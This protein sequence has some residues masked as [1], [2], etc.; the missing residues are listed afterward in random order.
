ML[1]ARVLQIFKISISAEDSIFRF[2]FILVRGENNSV[3]EAKSLLFTVFIGWQLM[4]ILAFLCISAYGHRATFTAFFLTSLGHIIASKNTLNDR[5][6]R[7]K[8]SL[9]PLGQALPPVT[10]S[11]RATP[12]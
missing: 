6:P 10:F 1:I 3:E 2:P 8:M 4:C 12:T 5:D 11:F 9:P 7:I